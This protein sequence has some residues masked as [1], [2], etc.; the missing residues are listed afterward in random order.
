MSDNSDDS[1]FTYWQIGY[2][3][4][5]GLSFLFFVAGFMHADKNLRRLYRFDLYASDAFIL[6]SKILAL[7]VVFAPLC[8]IWPVVDIICLMPVLYWLIMHWGPV[9]RAVANRPRHED[10]DD[11]E[12]EEEEEERKPPPK[13]SSKLSKKR[14]RE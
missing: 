4:G 2:L 14:Q 12:E 7:I 8:I 3:V 1:G 11:E 6:G 13:R 9:Q 10:S 5:Y